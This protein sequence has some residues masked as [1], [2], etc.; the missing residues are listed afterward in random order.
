MATAKLGA[1]WFNSGVDGADRLSL[2]NTGQLTR[3]PSVQGSTSRLAGG[4]LRSIA[5]EGRAT[6]WDV[7]SPYCTRAEQKWLAEHVGQLVWLR[8]AW[9]NKVLGVYY[10]VAFSQT[11]IND[12]ADIALKL[13]EVTDTAV[14]VSA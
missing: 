12:R 5:Q 3:S 4:R 7:S 8:D 1:L 14:V 6:Q 11:M 9:G 13:E 2:M 10:A